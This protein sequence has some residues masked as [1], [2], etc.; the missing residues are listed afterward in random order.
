MDQFPQYKLL[1]AKK[2]SYCFQGK[3][4]TELKSASPKF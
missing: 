3:K 2:V 1:G 4:L